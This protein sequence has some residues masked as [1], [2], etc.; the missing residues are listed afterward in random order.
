MNDYANN[1]GAYIEA[2][3]GV[4]EA[5]AVRVSGRL[6]DAPMGA[7]NYSSGIRLLQEKLQALST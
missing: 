2:W 5:D 7:I 1:A 6:G 3:G 4:K